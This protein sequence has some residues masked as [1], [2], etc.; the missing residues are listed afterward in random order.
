VYGSL[1]NY[2]CISECSNYGQCVCCYWNTLPYTHGHAASNL[3]V[4]EHRFVCALYWTN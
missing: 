3:M 4:P 2:K 1:L